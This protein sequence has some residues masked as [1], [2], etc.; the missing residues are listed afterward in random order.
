MPHDRVVPDAENYVRAVAERSAPTS[1][2]VIKQQVTLVPP[3]REFGAQRS[4]L[5]GYSRCT[6]YNRPVALALCNTGS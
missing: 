6:P 5:G 1:L 4:E 2:N 3:L